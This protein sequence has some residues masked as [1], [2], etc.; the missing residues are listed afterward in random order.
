MAHYLQALAVI[1][2]DDSGLVPNRA[3]HK[4]ASAPEDGSH[5]AG[6][7]ASRH[8][9]EPLVFPPLG[10]FSVDNTFLPGNSD[11]S[12]MASSH[13]PD[14]LT[15]SAVWTEQCTAVS[16][17]GKEDKTGLPLNPRR[18]LNAFH[19]CCPVPSHR[20]LRRQLLP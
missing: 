16:A 3:V 5:L 13:N 12:A 20:G 15:L 10:L 6:V 4:S 8:T 9:A 18:R 17:L 11:C 7:S 14:F 1:A 2:E 19:S